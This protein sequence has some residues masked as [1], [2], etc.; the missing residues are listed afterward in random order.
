MYLILDI[1]TNGLPNSINNSIY[2]INKWPNIIQISWQLHNNLG[3]LISKQNYKIYPKNF[4]INNNSYKIHK[5]NNHNIYKYGYNIKYI[6]NILKKD[7]LKSKYIIGYNIIFDIK[8]L[9]TECLRNKINFK[10]FKKK[11]IDIFKIF[12]KNNV[13]WISLKN[14]YYKIYN[15]NIYNLHNSQY[16]VLYTSRIFFYLLKNNKNFCKKYNINKN[17]IKNFSGGYNSKYLNNIC[18]KDN[19]IYY[20]HLHNYTY[21]SIL[22]SN[23][24]IKDLVKKVYRNNMPAFSVIERGN[25]MSLYKIYNY[26]LL[27]NKKYKTNIKY[28]IGIEFYIYSKKYK[29][30]FLY[31]FLSK[32]KRGYKNLLKLCYYSKNITNI[33]SIKKKYIKKYYKGL[34][35]LSGGIKSKFYFLIK[36]KINFK[37]I[38]KEILWWKKIFK[39]DFYIEIFNHNNKEKLLNNK[40]LYLSKKYN[41]K[42]IIQNINYFLNK[43][44]IKIYNILYNIKN[45]LKINKNIKIV[46]KDHYFKNKKQIYKLFYKKYKKGFKNLK[47]LVSKIKIYNIYYNNKLINYKIPKNYLQKHKKVTQYKYLKFL[48]YKS[49]KKKYKKINDKILNRIKYELKIIKSIKFSNYFLIIKDIINKAKK[50]NVLIGP[51]RGSVNGS[52]IAY[53]L[54]ITSIDPLKYNLLF[55]RFLNKDRKTL[56]DIDID[57]DYKGRKKIIKWIYKKYN[58]K[59]VCNIITY[60]HLNLKSSIRYISNLHNFPNEKIN[61]FIKLLNKNIYD[62]YN[63]INNKKYNYNN[64]VLYEVLYKYINKFYKIN[65]N[66]LFSILKTSLLIK[67]IIRTIGIH[68]CGILITKKKIYKYLPVIRIKKKKY[69]TQYN[70]YILQNMNLL[71][72]DFLSLHTL[73]I[74]KSTLKDIKK[75]VLINM[76][77][78]DKKVFDLFKDGKTKGIFQF[79]SD[80]IKKFLVKLSPNNFNDLIVLN[81]LYR[82][83]PIKYINKYIYR[84]YN[85][86]KIK[87][88]LPIMEKYL[89]E[90]YGIIIFQ[91]QV[92]LLSRV[93]S[94]FNKK[95]S[96]ILRIAMGKKNINLLNQ[97]KNKF[98]LGGLKNNHNKNILYKIWN[99]W[100]DFAH[101]AFNKSHS[102]SYAYLAYQT[103]YL[104]VHYNLYYVKN[105][106]NYNINNIT[107]INSLLKDYKKYYNYFSPLS[108]KNKNFY[109]IVKKKKIVFGLRLIKGIGKHFINKI[110]KVI[111][112]NKNLKNFYNF[113]KKISLN[114]INNRNI[115]IL[116]YSSLLDIFFK[117]KINKYYIIKYNKLDKLTFFLKKYNIINNSNKFFLFNQNN[118]LKNKIKKI[119]FNKKKIKYN[120]GFSY[121]KEKSIN[122]ISLINNIYNIYKYEIKYFKL[123]DMRYLNIFYY[124]KKKIYGVIINI[125]IK[126]N[127]NIIYIEDNFIIKEFYISKKNFNIYKLYIKKYY[128]IYMEIKFI[129]DIN[130]IIYINKLKN[131]F[132]KI[133]I[134]F[135]KK[136]YKKKNKIYL[137]N[138]FNNKKGKLQKIYYS[139]ISNINNIKKKKIYLLKNK[140]YKI[141]KFIKNILIKK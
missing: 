57:F 90:T 105:L 91:E 34:I 27:F 6:L 61:I 74:I 15:I 56:P 87:Y 46:K 9:L 35:Y 107:Y 79:E 38:N 66:K 136:I 129:N 104:K 117:K 39:K 64:Q 4:I 49:L 14:L 100:K 45:K 119:L 94:S 93:I 88:D 121:L 12:N 83:G 130:Y 116:I 42:Y 109:F 92:M 72:M 26:V 110:N 127:Y 7:I 128:V 131:L 18:K 133:L 52:L 47:E 1:E 21:Y 16:D 48:I 112:N 70:S 113:L 80:G 122:G 51:G 53:C 125:L 85:K 25:L 22:L 50:I 132:K 108:L 99:E 20:I 40:F 137:N 101:Y 8:I 138:F 2:K 54:N 5:I 23:T 29:K 115:K 19:N 24:K 11:Y 123:L 32:N 31:A 77:L 78:K 114:I 81:A 102:T 135:N 60:N 13:K 69:I 58:Y 75:D 30:F 65:N 134:I 28:I 55:E 96:D 111:K 67:G 82:P 68:A 37:K 120:I 103:A 84:K 33:C 118:Y 76:S 124:K 95:E 106:I 41:I 141:K 63:I 140:I 73:S 139:N 89:K 36:N 59:H 10:I 98:I 126:N 62:I 71:K 43:K 44:N 17:I 97:M 86:K 3:N